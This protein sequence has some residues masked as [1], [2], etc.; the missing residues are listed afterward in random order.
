LDLLQQGRR[1]SY[2]QVC[3][4]DVFFIA[5]LFFPLVDFSVANK[6][7]LQSSVFGCHCF[8]F[9]S[10]CKSLFD[11]FQFFCFI[12]FAKGDRVDEERHRL[13]ESQTQS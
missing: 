8:W 13:G 4:F 12:Q 6:L 11:F 5:L 2:K 7:M 10:N 1:G 3:L 9:C